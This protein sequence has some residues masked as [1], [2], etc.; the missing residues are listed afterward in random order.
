MIGQTISHY[1]ILSQLGGGGM[2]VVYYA[3]DIRLDRTF[4][5]K[6]PPNHFSER[7]ELRERF[8]REVPTIAKLNHPHICTLRDIAGAI[9]WRET[10][11]RDART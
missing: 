9:I 5:V 6:I 3:R 7:S 2:G 11:N 8:E 1:D 4:A 10:K